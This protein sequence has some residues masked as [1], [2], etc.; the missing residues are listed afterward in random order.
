MLKIV[1]MTM[2]TLL[3]S[4]MLTLAFHIQTVRAEPTTIIVPDDY[5]TIQAAINAAAAGDTIFVHKGTY[6]ENIGITKPL[7]V[8]G[9]EPNATIVA[10]FNQEDSVFKVQSDCVN[11]SGFTIQG[12][13]GAGSFSGISMDTNFCNISGNIIYSKNY[14]ISLFAPYVDKPASHNVIS[15]NIIVCGVGI[16]L[17]MASHNTIQDNYV[18]QASL[19]GIRL[20]S[21]DNN[22]I[23]NNVVDLNRD[24][25]G[26][27]IIGIGSTGNVITNNNITN[28]ECG[29]NP[30]QSNDNCIYHNNFVNNARQVLSEY[31]STNVWDNGYPVGGNYWDD[32]TGIDEKSGPNQ[33][34]PGSDGVGDTSYTIDDSNQDGYPFLQPNGWLINFTELSFSLNPNPGYVGQTV[35]MLGNLTDRLGN[36]ISNTRI[37]VY[38]NGS[39][40]RTLFTNSS[41]WFTASAQVYVA[42]TYN[43]TGVCN[44]QN[45]DP[46][47]H[48][49]TLTV[50]PKLDTKVT[51][52]L[53]PNPAH[54]GQWV[55]MSGNLT[56]LN[57]NL[58]GNAPLEL[59]VRTGAGPWQ[60]IG[61]IST[62]SSGEIWAFG[63]VMSADTY[64]VAV[65]YRGS[66]KYY[67][68]YHIETLIVNP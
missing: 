59:C 45:Y 13:T 48:M 15:K 33:D 60:H 29:L 49:E 31:S 19:V 10:A 2:L 58:I 18:G 52:T 8:F 47:S 30:R 22:A 4:T 65:V 63:R 27:Q 26:I 64:Q 11:I 32:Y 66:Y 55:L 62:G 50:Y 46:S 23:I 44:A 20:W 24:N 7:N 36:P 21:S 61:N 39:L 6:Y 41:G 54:L 5:P 42:G 56:D 17:F 67:L 25:G 28:N 14:G 37:D 3:L 51:F 40:S 34:K 57:D 9:E 68:N 43:L 1:F 38:V 35:T 12:A 16:S 53:S